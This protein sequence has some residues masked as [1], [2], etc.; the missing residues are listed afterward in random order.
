MKLNFMNVADGELI[1]KVDAQLVE[2][3]NKSRA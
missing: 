1:R 2:V 3:G